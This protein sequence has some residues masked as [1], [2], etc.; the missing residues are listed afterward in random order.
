MT[1]DAMTYELRVAGHLDRHWS[2]WFGGPRITHKNDDHH[3]R[4]DVADS[5]SCTA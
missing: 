3:L 5:R 2:S 4:S 1:T